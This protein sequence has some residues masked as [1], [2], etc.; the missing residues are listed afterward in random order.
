MSHELRTPLN[1]VIGFSDMLSMETF[2]S[3]G[4]ARNK[5]YVKDIHSSGVHLLALINDILDIA[6]IDAG[7]GQ[8]KEE[9]VASAR[10]CRQFAADGHAI[11]RSAARS[12][13]SRKSTPA[14]HSSAPT[15]GA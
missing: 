13:S 2:G 1:A 3:L 14:C 4:S 15:N 8:L 12:A 5:E 6:R 11:R 9:V 10:A 7:E